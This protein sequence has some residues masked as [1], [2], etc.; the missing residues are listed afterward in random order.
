MSIRAIIADDEPPARFRI[1]ELL[2]DAGDVEIVAEVAT[3]HEA[4]KAI[5]DHQPDLVF[6]DVQMPSPT[7]VALLRE[8]APE[9]RPCTIFTTAHQEHALDAFSLRATDYL[10]K[11][12]SGERFHEA[13]NRARE[14]IATRGKSDRLRRLLVRDGQTYTVV[15]VEQITHIE[16]ADNYVIVHT[17]SARFV[18][19]RTLSTLAADLD[20]AHFVRVNRATIVNLHFVRAIKTV[21]A[22]EHHL[23]LGNGSTVSFNR[24]VRELQAQLERGT[25][26]G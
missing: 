23:L 20:P 17:A 1:S 7:G 18:L 4:L 21:G 14:F 6:L 8:L 24:S 9:C 12:F 19:R 3:G 10:L 26:S 16:A 13:L 15:P 25:R 11:P 5:R 22:D 2:A